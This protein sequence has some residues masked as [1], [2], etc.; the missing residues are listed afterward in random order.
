MTHGRGKK[1]CEICGKAT[2]DVRD[3]RCPFGV[4]G[5][6]RYCRDCQRGRPSSRQ[7]QHKGC[8]EVAEGWEDT[9]EA[10]HLAAVKACQI[11]GADGRSA[12]ACKAWET[13]RA[14]RAIAPP[15]EACADVPF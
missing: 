3:I 14:G 8:A 12:A 4:C 13:R 7:D 6:H 10:R 9:R 11:R 15:P 5:E 1:A 2:L